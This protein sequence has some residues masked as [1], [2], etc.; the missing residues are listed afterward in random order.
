MEKKQFES[1]IESLFTIVPLFKRD[2]MK[3]ETDNGQSDLSPLQLQILFLLE[4]MGIQPMSEIG[5]HLQINKSNLTPLIQR[6]I[7]KELA[8]R[9]QDD[10]DRRYVKIGL[11]KQGIKALEAQKS[12]IAEQLKSKLS[13]LNPDEQQKLSAALA[14]VKSIMV[15]LL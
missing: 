2:I 10:K 11:T 5:K 7:D 9:I 4:D 8:E 1:I 13:A 14:E 12:R 15:K 3:P 6:L